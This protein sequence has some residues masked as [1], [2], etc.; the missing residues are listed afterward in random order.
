MIG[1]GQIPE[2]FLSYAH[3]TDTWQIPIC[4]G[5]VCKCDRIQKGEF[6]LRFCLKD[7]LDGKE[8]AYTPFFRLYCNQEPGAA[9]VAWR[10]LT[11][12]EEKEP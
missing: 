9:W 1:F 8:T 4:L 12:R 7:N 5:L 6:L 11:G 10:G 2:I 3:Q